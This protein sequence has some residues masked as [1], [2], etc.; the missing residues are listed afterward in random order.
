MIDLSRKDFE[1][2]IHF[3]TKAEGGRQSP[4][5]TGHRPNHDF[6][7][8][9]GINDATHEFPDVQVVQPGDTARS[10]V[11]LHA[12]ELPIGR[13]YSGM[14]FTVQEGSRIVGNGEIVKVLN[15]ELNRPNE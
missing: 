2:V 14:R 7:H 6:G 13:L 4:V 8:E 3:R 10:L 5:W 11:T 15:E 1:A 9:V 12:P